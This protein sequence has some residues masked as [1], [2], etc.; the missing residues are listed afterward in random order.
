MPKRTEGTSRSPGR[1]PD[2]APQP[3][4][5]DLTG[6]TLRA[7]WTCDDPAVTAAVDSTLRA[8]QELSRVWRS[9]GNEGGRGTRRHSGTPQVNT[10]RTG[11]KRGAIRSTS[12]P[13]HG[14]SDPP[15]GPGDGVG[16]HE[17]S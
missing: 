11:R 15:A 6:V 7:L 3:P 17:P 14:V 10:A 12:G 5:P 9:S 16:R 13:V 8:P 4:L 1:G 2:G